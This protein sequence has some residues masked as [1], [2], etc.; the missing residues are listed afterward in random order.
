M[1]EEGDGFTGEVVA[2]SLESAAVFDVDGFFGIGK[3][4]AIVAEGVVIDDGVGEADGAGVAVNG[5]AADA[6]GVAG[7]G[8]VGDFHGS[9]SE[10]IAERTAFPT[11]QVAVEGAMADW[12]RDAR[13]WG[14][15]E[16]ANSEVLAAGIS[17]EGGAQDA[18]TGPVGLVATGDVGG[19]AIAAAIVGEFAA[20]DP[21]PARG[22]M[23]PKCAAEGGAGVVFEMAADEVAVATGFHRA[24]GVMVLRWMAPPPALALVDWATLPMKVQLVA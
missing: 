17:A 2:E 18:A 7:E 1:V 6:G 23:G 20:V 19:S 3:L 15:E 24:R 14:D 8:A 22:G 10:V 21:Y 16:C 13:S 12:H 9:G 4:A 11:G 5:G